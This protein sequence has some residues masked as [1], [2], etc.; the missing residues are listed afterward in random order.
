MD[1][2]TSECEEKSKVKV[3]KILAESGENPR[4]IVDPSRER[5]ARD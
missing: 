2:G 5:F 4:G 1:F 3:M